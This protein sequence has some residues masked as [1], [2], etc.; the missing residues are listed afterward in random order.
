MLWIVGGRY[1]AGLGYPYSVRVS[2]HGCG[3]AMDNG[4]AGKEVSVS[5][6][7]EVEE[8]GEKEDVAEEG[9]HDDDDAWG[10]ISPP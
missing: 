3:C 4:V 1:G 10:T 8:E 2:I 5:G 9:D 6:K 7:E